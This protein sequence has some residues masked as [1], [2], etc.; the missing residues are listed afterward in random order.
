MS[1]GALARQS[2]SR[3]AG[4]G[5]AHTVDDGTNDLVDL[6]ISGRV[7]RCEALGNCGRDSRLEGVAESRAQTGSAGLNRPGDA[8]ARRQLR[9]PMP[10]PRELGMLDILL[11][12]LHGDEDGVVNGEEMG[13]TGCDELHEE[14]NEEIGLAQSPEYPASH[15][16][17]FDLFLSSLDNTSL[18]IRPAMAQ[19]Q[20]IVTQRSMLQS[21]RRYG[22][23]LA[24]TRCT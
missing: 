12:H 17:G 8:A 9:G 2:F 23:A 14:Q 11:Q 16:F 20:R 4:E 15:F 1:S 24:K 22:M 6:S 21:C 5:S 18:T 19:C 3:L 7:A 10:T 13:V